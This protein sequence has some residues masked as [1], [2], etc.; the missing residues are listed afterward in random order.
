MTTAPTERQGTAHTASPVRNAGFDDLVKMLE[1]Q[2]SRKIDMVIP[3]EK[4]RFENGMLIVEGQEMIL[5]D[6]GFTDPNGTYWPTQTFD[7]QVAEKLGINAAYLRR[8]RHGRVSTKTSKEASPPRLDLW[9]GNVNGL[10]HGRRQ[11]S[12]TVYTHDE[13][14]NIV[15][16]E[17]VI[18]QEALPADGRSFF[19]RLF[20]PEEGIGV[21]R[22]MLSNGYGPFDHFD[23]LKAVLDGIV[24]AGVEPKSLKIRGDL[25]ETRMF[26]HITAPEILVAAPGLLDG[27][28]SPFESS[29]EQGRRQGLSPMSLE[30]RLAAGRR[31]LEGGGRGQG[32]HMFEPGTEPLLCAGLRVTNSETGTGRLSVVPEVELLRCTNGLTLTREGYNRNHIGARLEDGHWS[33]ATQN[34]NLELITSMICDVVKLALDADFVEEKVGEL[35]RKAGKGIPEPEKVI[36]VV[37]QRLSFSKEERDGVLRHFLMGGQLTSGGVMNAITSFSQTVPDSDAAHD[38]SDK[39]IEAMELAFSLA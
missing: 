4:M 38:L 32:H 29:S 39:A 34:K 16:N 17:Q 27:Y 19:T 21:A 9:D 24:A 37:A 22:A 5:D 25:S 13:E 31:W 30:E 11:R 3:A 7:D 12:R 1:G 23:A 8:L 10:L 20:R 26:L 15:G 2:Q 14:H 35:E 36:E 33:N 28:R 6:D 18:R